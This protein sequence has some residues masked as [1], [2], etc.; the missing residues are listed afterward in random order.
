MNDNLQNPSTN[1]ELTNQSLFTV[2]KIYVKDVSLEVPNAPQIFLVQDQPKIDF[3]LNFATTKIDEHMYEVVMHGVVDAKVESGQMFLIEID[4]AGIFQ[5]RNI[6]ESQMQLL[7]NIE[8]PS[9]LFPYLRE[10]ISDLT[11]KAG[12]LPVLLA[13]VNFA[14]L[15]HQK[16]ESMLNNANNPAPTIN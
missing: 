4:I 16:Q 12:F 5:M 14:Y 1:E 9:I 15:Y 6:P 2:D 7:Q 3:N 10:M 11:V 8:C 13:P